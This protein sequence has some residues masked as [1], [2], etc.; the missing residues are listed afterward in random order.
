[1]NEHGAMSMLEIDVELPP[2]APSG[3]PLAEVEEVELPP[4]RRATA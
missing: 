3:R 1:M 2:L 4:R